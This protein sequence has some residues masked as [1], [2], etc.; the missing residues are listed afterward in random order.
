MKKSEVINI[1]RE[2]KEKL[3]RF[4]VKKIGVFGSVARDEATEKSDIDIVVEFEKGKA[5]FKNVGGLI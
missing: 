4:G 3:K 1:L 5:T 2:N